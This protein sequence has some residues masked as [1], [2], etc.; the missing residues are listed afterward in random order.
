MSPK[1]LSKIAFLSM[2]GAGAAGAGLYFFDPEAGSKRRSKLMKDSKKLMAAAKH[3]TTKSLRDAGHHMFGGIACCV[4]RIRSEQAT[5]EVIVER[6]RSRM[7]RVVAHPHP[8]KVVSD[9]GIVTLWGPVA[10]DELL[11]LLYK[12]K[13]TPGVKEIQNHLTTYRSQEKTETVPGKKTGEIKWGPFKRLLIGVAGATAAAYG[14]YKKNAF[15]RALTVAGAGAMASSTMKRRISSSLA[16]SEFDQGFEVDQTINLNAP[17]SDVFD[18]WANPENYPQAFSHITSVEQIGENLYRWTVKGPGG[19]PI[20]WEGVITRI[21]PN[22]LVE[23]KSQPGSLIGNSGSAR[24][25]PNYDASTR[26]HIRMFYRPP[27]GIL[28]RF[29]AEMFGADPK[30]ILRDDLR[31]LKWLFESGGIRLKQERSA[32]EEAELLKMAT[33]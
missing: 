10:K 32:E 22:T 17:V 7:G 25:D 29:V 28:G 31:R 12:V 18:F 11:P 5:D 33:T 23:W 1:Q 14:L 9:E 16:L 13:A 20:G 27:A 3:E 8:I 30:S 6:V 4:S 21:V 15:G 26:L 24:F 2:L 19:I